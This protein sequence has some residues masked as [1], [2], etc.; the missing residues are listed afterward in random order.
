MKKEKEI[1]VFVRVKVNDKF[2][3]SYYPSYSTQKV[4]LE[5]RINIDVELDFERIL[6]VM[7]K[8]ISLKRIILDHLKKR[9]G[10]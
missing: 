3:Q 2:I 5:N 6:D 9:N 7:L 1:N 4:P 8:N 10:N